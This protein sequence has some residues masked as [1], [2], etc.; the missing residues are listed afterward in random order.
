[1]L[2]SRSK[3]LSDCS[4]RITS[5]CSIRVFQLVK[6]R[7]STTQKPQLLKCLFDCKDIF[8]P[9]GKP[10]LNLGYLVCYIKFHFLLNALYKFKRGLLSIRFRNFQERYGL[11]NLKNLKMWQSHRIA[12]ISSLPPIKSPGNPCPANNM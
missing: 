5:V 1:M 8:N 11:Q 3:Y 12:A 9:C 4:A 10:Y 6:F 2:A 7:G